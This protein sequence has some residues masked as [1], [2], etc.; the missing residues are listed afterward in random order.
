M[1]GEQTL[2]GIGTFRLPISRNNLLLML[3]AFTEIGMGV[4]TYLAHL[5]SGDVKPMEAIPVF[6]GPIAGLILLLA[7]FLRIR[8]GNTLVTTLIVMGVAGASVAVGVIGSAFHWAR[9]VPPPG[10]G[11][12]R[13]DFDWLVFAPPVA[14]PLAFAGVGILAIIAV[15]EDTKPETGTLTL[16]GVLTFKTPLPQTRQFLWLVAFG[17]YAA[18]LSA[19]LD[20]GRT[21][22][23][24]IFVWIPVVFGLFGSVVTTLMA[25]YHHHT[26][27]DYFIFFWVMVGMILMGILG[28]GLHVNADLPEGPSGGVNLERFVRGAP[29]MAPMLFAIMGAFGIITMI[30]AETVD[31]EN[32]GEETVDQSSSASQ[33][34]S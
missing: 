31:Q 34:T 20:H 30:G 12:Q 18:T 4:E 28:L 14:G 9:A 11:A 1:L 2:P 7:M 16:P 26:K 22:F 33:T 13:L 23:E 15:L 8:Q 3:V 25:V 10:L 32:S 5:I 24:N 27:A 29:V 6:F 21:E 19:F 17:L